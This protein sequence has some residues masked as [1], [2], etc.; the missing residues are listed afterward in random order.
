MQLECAQNKTTDWRM[1]IRAVVVI[2][3]ETW[4]NILVRREPVYG[5]TSGC[6]THNSNCKPKGYLKMTPDAVCIKFTPWHGICSGMLK[7]RGRNGY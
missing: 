3:P 4:V 6:C 5:V 2:V 7:M 1:V